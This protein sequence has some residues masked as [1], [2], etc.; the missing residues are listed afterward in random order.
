M[1]RETDVLLQRLRSDAGRRTLA[2]LIQERE[3]AACKIERLVEELDKVSARTSSARAPVPT[4]G[5]ARRDGTHWQSRS[6]LRLKEV[7]EIL[8]VSRS[9]IYAGMN[10]GTF[11]RSVMISDRAVRWRSGDIA[12]WLAA[13]GVK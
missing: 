6:L 13:R 7:C 4:A 9:T 10:A 3:A 2:E 5:D 1:N 11:P 12:T 8:G